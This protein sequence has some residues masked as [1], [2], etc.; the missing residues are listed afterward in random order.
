MSVKDVS[1]WILPPVVVAGVR[2]LSRGKVEETGRMKFKYGDFVLQCDSSHHLPTILSELPDFGRNLA[3]IVLTME[4]REPRVID[5]GANIGDTAV[6]LARFAPGAKVLCVEG[7][8]HFMPDLRVNTSQIT[9]VVLAEAILSDRTFEGRGKFVVTQGTAHLE[10]DANGETIRMVT[11]DDLVKEYV[12]FSSPH[13]IKVDTD[14]FD[15][16]ILRGAKNL[17]IS[18]RPVVFYEWHPHSYGIAGENDTNHS[19]FLMSLGYR[20][21]I[22]YTNKGEPLLITESPGR[23]IWES[24]GQFSRGRLSVDGWHY[25]IA[26]FPDE[27]KDVWRRLAQH[28][29]TSGIYGHLGRHSA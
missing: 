21:F 10:L 3:D 22:I 9:G 1:R 17:L 18:S 5:V 26:A 23:D 11:L 7:D 8:P 20:R 13:V 6:L 19:D 15:P 16:A 14:G 24:L 2:W 29:S 25:D 4:V 27:R 28:Y 12:E